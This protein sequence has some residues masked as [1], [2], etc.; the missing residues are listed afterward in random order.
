MS[1]LDPEDVQ[2]DE[3]ARRPGFAP[4]QAIGLLVLLGIAAFVVFA[5]LA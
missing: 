2:A 3:R 5:L 4:V 1:D